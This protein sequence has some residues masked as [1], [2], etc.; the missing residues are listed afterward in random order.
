[1]TLVGKITTEIGVHSTAEKWYNLFAKSLH[2]V[3]HLTDSVHA[4]QLHQGEDWHHNDTIKHWTYIVDGKVAKCHEKIESVD[5]KNKTIYYKLFGEDIDHRFKVFKLIFQAIDKENGGAII[6]WS[7]EYE[8]LNE[9]VHAPYGWVE[10]LHNC[11]RDIDRN[12]VMKA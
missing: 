6:K 7:V 3:Q 8:K 10:Y 5:E 9:E 4:T 11:T 12:L 1:M 2:D